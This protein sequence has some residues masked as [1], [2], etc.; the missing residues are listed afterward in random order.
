MITGQKFSLVNYP[1]KYAPALQGKG[2]GTQAVVAIFP[3]LKVNYGNYN[4][5]YLTVNCKNLGAKAC[6]QKGGFE[7]LDDEYLGGAE[8]AQ[9]IMRGTIA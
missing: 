9:Y 5:I 4:A 3:Y 7:S 1:T 6:Y 2:M 8:G